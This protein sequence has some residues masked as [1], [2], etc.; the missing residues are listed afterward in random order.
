M[1]LKE[2][3]KTPWQYILT[4]AKWLALGILVGAIGGLIGAAF[5]HTLAFASGLR[6][7]NSWLI[8]LLPVGGTPS[9]P[10]TI[11]CGSPITAAPT[12]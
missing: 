11:C 5:H 8:Y 3:L 7:A 12:R 10:F 6:K 2:R 9:P 1:K 4:F